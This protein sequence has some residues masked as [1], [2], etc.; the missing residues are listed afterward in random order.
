MQDRRP[1]LTG[2]VLA[3]SV[4]G[5]A[6]ASW[7]DP[8]SALGAAIT[9]TAALVVATF[10]SRATAGGLVVV[11]AA[12][13]SI[14][15]TI[16]YPRPADSS[17]G[18]VAVAEAIGLLALIVA[19][20]RLP[21]AWH[22]VGCGVA[23][24]VATSVLILRLAEVSS[25]AQ[26]VGTA[27]FGLV[28]AGVVG[29][30]AAVVR[31]QGQ[32]RRKQHEELRRTQREEIAKDLHDYLGHDLTGILVQAQAALT[33][34]NESASDHRETLTNI[35]ADATHALATLDRVIATLFGPSAPVGAAPVES[36]ARPVP[37]LHDVPALVQR[38]NETGT[39][40]TQLEG[41]TVL[42]RSVEPEIGTTIFRL[43]AEALTNI[44]RHAPAAS[45]AL[46][47]LREVR[48]DPGGSAILV[49]VTN[50]SVPAPEQR[51]TRA[52]GGAGLAGL[53]QRAELLGG[54]VEAGFVSP[55]SWR[56]LARFPLD[57]R[58]G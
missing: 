13:S 38:F 24:A 49:E 5:A 26:A 51:L 55:T 36:A 39:T 31:H 52:R 2:I 25:F 16:F 56:V 32:V 45:R 43:V 50:E 12:S 14:L 1:A 11:L 58:R 7:V 10:R 18:A 6:I 3:P 46:V 34:D 37:G 30:A 23:A 44:R 48:C 54:V 47:T 40:P 15:I 41:G 27:L 9:L 35:A 19:A 4:V 33:I 53:S 28:V 57:G 22:A 20:A 29:G 21:T 17:A 8:L 42:H